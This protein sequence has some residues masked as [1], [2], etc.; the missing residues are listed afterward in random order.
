MSDRKCN[1]LCELFSQAN[2]VPERRNQYPELLTDYLRTRYPAR[3][4]RVVYD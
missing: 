4:T 1:T 3:G 2:G